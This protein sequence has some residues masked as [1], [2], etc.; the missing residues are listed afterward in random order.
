MGAISAIKLIVLHNVEYVLAVELLSASQA[1][2][3]V[4]R[5]NQGRR[6]SPLLRQRIPTQTAIMKCATIWKYASACCARE[7]S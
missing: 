7:N 1:L 4:V 6:R 5:C 2:D 3:F